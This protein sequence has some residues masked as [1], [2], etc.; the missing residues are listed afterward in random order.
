MKMAAHTVANDRR[1]GQSEGGTR[2][3]VVLD[4]Q[5]IES[6]ICHEYFV[7][8]EAKKAPIDIEYFKLKAITVSYKQA[9][10]NHTVKTLLKLSAKS[11][12]SKRQSTFPGIT[13]FS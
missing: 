3:L 13:R 4:A 8:Y 11:R 7:N 2:N 5:W 6:T 10:S 12:Q 1:R 9:I